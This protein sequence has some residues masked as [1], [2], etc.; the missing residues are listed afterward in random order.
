MEESRAPQRDRLLNRITRHWRIPSGSCRE[1]AAP[2]K[3]GRRLPFCKVGGSF[4]LLS[5]WGHCWATDREGM[6]QTGPNPGWLLPCPP[7]PCPTTLPGGPSP[8]FP[9][10]LHYLGPHLPEPPTPC[11]QGLIAPGR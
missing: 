6:E 9:H 5:L 3:P 10:Q 1:A 11:C 8:P 7:Q 2:G 4:L